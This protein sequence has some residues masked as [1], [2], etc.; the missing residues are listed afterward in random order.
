[1]ILKS[2]FFTRPTLKVSWELLGKYLCIKKNGKTQSHIITEVEA[3]DGPCDKACHGFKGLTERTKI[4]F[5]PAGHWYVY[6]CYGMYWML[7]I[8][9]DN[10]GYPAAILIRGAGDLNGP[11]KLTRDLGINKKFNGLIASKKTG[12]WLEDLGTK[13]NPKK[14]LKT[15]RIG[16]NYAGAWAAKPYRFVLTA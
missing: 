10:P 5:G 15:P 7:N 12:L 13:I 2:D 9:T 14:I 11:G 6:L 16:V 4:M 8:T 3:Y 1:M